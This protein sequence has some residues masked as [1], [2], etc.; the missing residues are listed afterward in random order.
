MR[1]LQYDRVLWDFN[2]TIYDDLAHCLRTMNAVLAG[3]GL[4][5]IDGED[6]YREVFCFPVN[7][8]YIR[9]GLPGEGDGFVTAAHEWVEAYRRGEETLRIREG[10]EEVLELIRAS[11]VP[12]SVLSATERTMLKEQISAL[13][14]THYFG[15]LL[16]RGDI[17]AT[18]KS[19]IAVQY[20]AAH[21]TERVLMIGDTT[22]DYATAAAG[23]FD[24]VLVAGGHQSRRA[25]ESCG[26]P[27]VADF[28]ALA[29][30]LQEE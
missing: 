10:V 30:Y 25:L 20:A 26:C 19:D 4:P 12:Q 18:D 7:I 8:Y 28:H 14:I 15:D 11:G 9:V 21:P 16:G 17:Y 24:C 29:A 3:R 23:G 5:L 13:G 2:G 27:V 22:H 6:A 1:L